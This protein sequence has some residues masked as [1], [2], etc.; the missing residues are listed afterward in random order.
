MT[1]LAQDIASLDIAPGS[2]GIFWLGQAGFAVKTPAGRL[3]YIDPYL[4][5]MCE[6]TLAGGIP[7][8]RL[9]PPPMDAI[10]IDRGVIV[11]THAHQD[12]HDEESIALIAREHPAVQFAGPASCIQ[13][14]EKML[15]PGDRMHLLECGKPCQFDGFSVSA[16]FADHGEAMPDA[17]GVVLEVDGIRVYHTGDTSYQP[18][19]MR[20]VM[21][22]QP[23]VILPCI[24][25]TYGN[26]NGA[27]AARLANDVSA[28][29][30]IPSHFWCFI[31]QNTSAEGTP[32][33][34][35]EACREF[36]PQTHPEVLRVGE[37]YIYRR[38]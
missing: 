31:A 23:D 17:V 38:G 10:E 30:A 18:E 21:D 35:L 37:S 24:N 6:T 36:A 15:I 16:V 14:L 19:K 29:V 26:L 4:S 3:I 22:L 20:E 33:A 28:K 8:K 27:E 2:I 32:A 34:F 5:Y 25:G 11:S 7:S 12:H 9:F 1:K 13:S